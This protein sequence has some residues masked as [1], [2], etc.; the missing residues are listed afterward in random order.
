MKKCTSFEEKKVTRY[1]R[2]NLYFC[3]IIFSCLSSTRLCLRFPFNCFVRKI[4][5]F[6]QSSLGNKVDFRDIMNVSPN[7]LDINWNFKKLR[8]GFI[9]ERALIIMTLIS[10]CHWKTVILFCLRNKRPENAFLT[11]IVNYRKSYKKQIMPFKTTVILLFNVIR[12]YLVISCFD[13]KIS[14]FQHLFSKQ[15]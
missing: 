7:I 2:K 13:W 10:S 12:C 1:I 6:Y 14:V 9:N 11:L 15:L 3:I 8:H 4:K 5:G